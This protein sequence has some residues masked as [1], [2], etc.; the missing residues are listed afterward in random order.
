[1]LNAQQRFENLQSKGV[2][3]CSMFGVSRV[4]RSERSTSRLTL[5]LPAS[6]P[7]LKCHDLRRN[8]LSFRQLFGAD[9]MLYSEFQVYFSGVIYVS[10]KI[11]LLSCWTAEDPLTIPKD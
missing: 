7:S 5:S 9:T 10:S 8:T 3:H 11:N 4:V 6:R 1:M 2:S